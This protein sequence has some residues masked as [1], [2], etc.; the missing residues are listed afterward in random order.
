MREMFGLHTTPVAGIT[1]NDHARAFITGRV[2][3]VCGEFK[4][5]I[6]VQNATIPRNGSLFYH[7]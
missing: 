2:V 1:R 6:A 5:Y 7:G 4:N 3:F